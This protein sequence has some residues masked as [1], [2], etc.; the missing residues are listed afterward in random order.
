MWL[1]SK[2]TED[3]SSEWEERDAIFES[4]M[5]R[6]HSQGSQRHASLKARRSNPTKAHELLGIE[7]KSPKKDK[8]G[9][10]LLRKYDAFSTIRRVDKSLPPSPSSSI[11]DTPAQMYAKEPV[12]PGTDKGRRSKSLQGKDQSL[13]E[14][15]KVQTENVPDELEDAAELADVERNS[16]QDAVQNWVDWITSFASNVGGLD[17]DFEDIATDCSAVSYEEDVD[18]EELCCW[19]DS[20][21]FESIIVDEDCLDDGSQSILIGLG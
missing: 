11:L 14:A 13:V 16:K 7:V 2:E 10:L 3:S 1:D 17:M 18:V 8:F 4:L 15:G 20:F 19:Y 9:P 12:L 5:T 21:E 6:H